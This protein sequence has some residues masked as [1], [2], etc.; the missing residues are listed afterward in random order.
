MKDFDMYAASSVECR[1]LLGRHMDNTVAYRIVVAKIISE[2]S[3][4]RTGQE[5]GG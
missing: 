2:T 4:W 5:I 3:T 1:K